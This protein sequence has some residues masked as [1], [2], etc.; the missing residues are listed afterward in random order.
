MKKQWVWLLVFALLAGAGCRSKEKKEAGMKE[1]ESPAKVSEGIG[2]KSEWKAPEK[3]DVDVTKQY[4]ATI[5]TAKGDIR[6]ELQPKEA[7]LS[8]TNFVQ[9]AQKGFYNGLT[10]HR[11]VPGFVAQGGD[12]TGNGTGGPGYTLPAE[13]GLKHGKGA[14]AW[15]RLP[16]TDPQGN[17][18]NPE[19]RSSGSQ[20]YITLD[21]QPSLDGGYTV[22]GKTVSGWETLE[23]IQQGDA[24]QEITVETK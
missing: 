3:A 2:G 17:P 10:F 19:K 13:I 11:V 12:P 1:M 6:A 8:V 24:I 9:L 4:F 22:F 23:A 5:K 20:F 16:E 7:P 14:L 21:A 15:A 18:I